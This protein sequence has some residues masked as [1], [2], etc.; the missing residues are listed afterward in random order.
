M[1]SL[2]QWTQRN[3]RSL[4][5]AEPPKQ[6][7]ALRIGLLGASKIAYCQSPL[8]PPTNLSQLTAHPSPIAVINA[9][10][11]HPGVIIAAVAARD[12]ARA[13][14]YAKTHKIPNVHTSY[15]ALIDDRTIDAIYNPLPNGLHYEWTMKALKAGK[16][17]LLEKP[18]VSN[19]DEARKLFRNPL[20]L[21]NGGKLVVLDA[22]H[23]RFHPAWQKFLSLIDKEEIIEANSQAWLPKWLLAEDDIRFQYSL[24]GGCLMDLGSYCLQTLRQA[25]GAEPSECISAHATPM[26]PGLDQNID[27]MFDATWRFPNG[28]IGTIHADSFALGRYMTWLTNHLPPFRSPKFEVKHREKVIPH[29]ILHGME[30]ATT[31]TVI[32]WDVICQ[33][34]W[35]RIDVIEDHVLRDSKTGRVAKKWTDTKYLKQYEGDVGDASWTTYRHMLEQFVNKIRGREGT[36]IWVDGED[37]I[38]QM[39]M[40]DGAYKKAGLPVRPSIAPAGL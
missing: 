36:G 6:S 19:A 4:Y 34:L 40:I 14:T 13:H 25:F 16:H 24:A 10:N 2:I 11:T 30:T 12:E 28:G 18:S 8:T 17:V 39:E 22:V 1:A 5:P 38:R 37:S 15:Q 27:R 26:R 35:H 7:D 21:G 33:S 23:I 29:P 31:K 3:W 20:L 9:A 32:F